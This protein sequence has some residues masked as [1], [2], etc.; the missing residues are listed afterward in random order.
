MHEHVIAY[1][2]NLTQKIYQNHKNP[3]YP[4]KNKNLGLKCMKCM[5]REEKKGFRP[6]TNKFKLEIGRKCEGRRFLVKK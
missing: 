5:R 3:K 2:Q 4:N 1:Q 6:L